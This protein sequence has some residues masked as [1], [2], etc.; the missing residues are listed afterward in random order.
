MAASNTDRF[1]KSKRKFETTVGVGGILAGGTTLPL[2]SVTGLDT[3][4]AVT[5]VVGAGT[6]TEEVI[7]G[8]V[9]G[10]DLINCVRGKEGTT[11]SAH[12]AG[13]TVNMFFT[14]THWDDMVDGITQDHGQLGY[15]K[16]LTDANGNEWIR[17]TATS[18]AVNDITVAN[19][20]T[21]NAPIISATGDDTNIDLYLNGKGTGSA[22][23]AGPQDG[24][25]ACNETLTYASA[26]TFTCSAALAGVLVTGD[27]IKL[28]QTTA[29]YFY[30]V[31]I[32]GTTVTVTGG[33]DYSL[34]NAAITLPFYS[35]SVSPVG[36]P[37]WF[38]YT[39]TWTN[40][41]VGNAT[42]I[43]RYTQIGKTVF[44]QIKLTFGNT[45]SMGTGP[46]FTLP[47]PEN[48]T[49]YPALT[50]NYIGDFLIEDSGTANY[51]GTVL[52]GGSG[53]SGKAY[54]YVKAVSGAYVNAANPITSTIPMTWT[55]NDFITLAF[56][57]E[58]A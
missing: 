41:T 38:N 39:P 48:T 51:T 54:L 27:K 22:R 13:E 5:L 46:R 37:Q 31:S 23:F 28:T 14:E 16:S 57:Y 12:S 10:S 18:S 56:A 35:K 1:K 36:F 30:V 52:I 33:S 44:V 15:H 19:A 42:T 24:W 58:A 9:S 25:I 29:K 49:T 43:Y 20:A 32:S 8:V 50:N 2:T 11:D 7:T 21:T 4:T 6:A 53:G 26:T 55:T 3:S 40:L 34:A 17:Q 45:S 47:V